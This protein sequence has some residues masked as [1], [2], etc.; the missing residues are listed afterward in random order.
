VASEIDLSN[1]DCLP[2]V[3]DRVRADRADRISDG[4]TDRIPADRIPADRV[5]GVPDAA[6]L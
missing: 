5:D 4:H 3:L 6:A 1:R 2:P